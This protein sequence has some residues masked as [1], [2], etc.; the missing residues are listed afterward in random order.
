[1]TFRKEDRDNKSHWVI[2]I[3]YKTAGGKRQRYRRDAQVQTRTGAE[4][5]H[6]RL[7]SELAQRGTLVREAPVPQ[8][9]STAYTFDDAVRHFRATHM[10]NGIKPSTR[11]GYAN[12]IDMLLMPRFGGMSLDEVDGGALT[13]LDVDLVADE[14]A[15][16]TRG[17]IQTVLRS[18]LRSAVRAGMLKTMPVL[19]PLPKVG[20]KVPRP[21]RRDD[22]E[23]IVGVA[24]AEG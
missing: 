22:L 10:K 5:E 17:K 19:P 23:A 9:P 15:S 2:D 3:P 11:A 21:M 6:R 16:S 1:M 14:L 12:R 4:A 24:N 8:A 7:I 18:V 20:R 13:K